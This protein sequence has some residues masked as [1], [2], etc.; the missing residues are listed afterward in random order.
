MKLG[1]KIR[2]VRLGKGITIQDIARR[3]G[4]SKGFLSQVENDKTSPS[5]GTL[6]RIAEALS[7]PLT[8]LL[9][10]EH[11][12]PVL[13]R[14]GERQVLID[15]ASQGRLEYLSPLTGRSLQLVLVELPAGRAAGDRRH[16]HEGEE[17]CWV[18]AGS[19][20]VSQGELALTLHEGDAFFWDGSVPHVIE[21]PG[22]QA[23][24]LLLAMSPPAPLRIVAAEGAGRRADEL[25]APAAA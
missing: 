11:R 13:I 24:R 3:T 25:E 15:E 22:P 5:L 23:A 12:A 9:L 18:L 19:V 4:L 1:R 17:A 7:I 14:R 6:E 21:N 20:R 8:Y 16:Q 10:E 2:S